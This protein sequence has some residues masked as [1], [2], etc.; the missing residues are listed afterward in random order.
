MLYREEYAGFNVRHFH[1]EITE[2][3]EISVSYTWAKL[4]PREK[5]LLGVR[6]ESK[7]S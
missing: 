7:I 5:W 4:L 6:V 1:E 3:E 2:K